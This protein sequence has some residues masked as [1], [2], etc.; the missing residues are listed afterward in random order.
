[1]ATQVQIEA[2]RKRLVD[3]WDAEGAC[4]SCGW[5]GALYEH[6]VTDDDLSSALDENKG[7]LEL[8][9]VNKDDADSWSHRGVKIRIDA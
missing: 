5:H 8:S 6:D 3:K 1:M 9:C 2:A 4:G 7:M